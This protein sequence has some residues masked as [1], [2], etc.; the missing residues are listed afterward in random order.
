MKH[1]TATSAKNIRV[2]P[3][4]SE[5]KAYNRR[6][7]SCMHVGLNSRT[8]A[9]REIPLGI[10]VVAIVRFARKPAIEVITVPNQ[11]SARLG[12]CPRDSLAVRVLREKACALNTDLRAI[13]L[14][15]GA[16]A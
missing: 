16:K 1:Q 9:C 3:G 2:Q 15:R 6:S 14:S 8:F 4:Y 12:R 7:S 10:A 5:R 11:K 13:F